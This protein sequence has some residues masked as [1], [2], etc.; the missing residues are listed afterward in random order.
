MAKS[1]K[2]F[3]AAAGL[4]DKSNEQDGELKKDERVENGLV[5]TQGKKGQKLPRINMAFTTENHTYIKRRSR[6]E[7]MSITEYVNRLID[8]DRKAQKEL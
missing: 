4:F 3:G 6:Q 7:G 1:K 5:G 8:D 2:S